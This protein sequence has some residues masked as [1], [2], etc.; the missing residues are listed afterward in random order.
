MKHVVAL[1]NVCRYISRRITGEARVPSVMDSI[2]KC[3]KNNGEYDMWLTLYISNTSKCENATKLYNQMP[4]MRLSGA[5][6]KS[7]KT[8][9][10]ADSK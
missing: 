2:S 3:V 8:Q 9:K 4:P 6:E 1:N 10:K 5:D 7:E